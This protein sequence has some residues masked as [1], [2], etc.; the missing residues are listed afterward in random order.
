M[1][2][3][4]YNNLAL[5]IT[6]NQSATKENTFAITPS[7]KLYFL[8]KQ[9]GKIDVVK[10]DLD[11]SNRQT[12]L[13]GTGQEEE[14]NTVLL[15]SRDWK[16]LA[17]QSRRESDKPR[18]YLIDTLTDKLTEIDSGNA[19]FTPVGWNDHA[20]IYK[21]N[22]GGVLSWQ[23]KAI[24]LKT[25]N[26]DTLQLGTIDET[27]AEGSSDN[28]FANEQIDNVYILKD[29]VIYTK[30]WS[31]NYYSAYRLAG[32]RSGIYTVKPNGTARQVLKDFDS[33]TYTYIS[34]LPYKPDE[35]YFSVNSNNKTDYYEYEE[36]AVKEDK[37]LNN[38]S[39]NKF[40]ATYLA[41]PSGQSTFWYEPRDG[42][43]TLFTGTTDGSSP[44]QVASL[45]E[46]TPYGWYSDNYL[47]VSKGGSE[48]F[49][50][51]VT[52]VD[53]KTAILKVTDYHKPSV[54]FRGYG[55]GYGGN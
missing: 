33:G 32:K 38:E 48:L 23:P 13:A 31:A 2:A 16:Y 52:G 18:L 51:P 39:F 45:G 15:A 49:I 19:T 43:N 46:Y 30:S 53:T 50:M 12:V 28:D 29:A 40:Y 25:Y 14:T 6:V 36:G 54:S 24:A 21:V 5:Q 41:S 1:T 42:K 44:K 8:S 37:E 47:L 4:D 35:I 26:A 11:G 7:G 34:A 17:L 3:K 9:T 10:T 27:N 20:F 55:Y 22:R